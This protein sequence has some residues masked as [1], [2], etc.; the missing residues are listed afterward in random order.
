[1]Q[2]MDGV[3]AR[4]LT[5]QNSYDRAGAGG[6][7]GHVTTPVVGVHEEIP[8]LLVLIEVVE[9]LERPFAGAVGGIDG[10]IGAVGNV[11]QRGNDDVVGQVVG[12]HAVVFERELRGW[13][14]SRRG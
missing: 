5:G 6:V 4:I 13:P 14:W 11:V 2:M 7:L 12:V 10:R 3:I 9:N 8:V 1:M